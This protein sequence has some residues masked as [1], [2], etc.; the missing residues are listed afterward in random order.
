MD[1]GGFDVVQCPISIA[2]RRFC[3]SRLL[4]EINKQNVIMNIR[5]IFLQGLLVKMPVKKFIFS[6]EY[7]K[8]FL[9]YEHLF[10]GYEK[11]ILL[12]I[13]SVL[14]DI[15]ASIVVGVE[16]SKQLQ[17]IYKMFKLKKDKHLMTDIYKSRKLWSNLPKNS[18]DPRKW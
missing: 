8:I 2:D 11:K 5:S 13:K 1:Y 15:K 10:P 16:S 6:K 4:K 9:E 17:T 7:K 3:D 18:I 14:D 12:A